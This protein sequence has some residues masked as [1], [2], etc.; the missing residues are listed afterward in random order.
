MDYAHATHPF[1]QLAA[2][3]QSWSALVSLGFWRSAFNG[4]GL[5]LWF[6]PPLSAFRR[7]VSGV[8]H[9]L[10]VAVRLPTAFDS[11]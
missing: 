6:V 10:A 11:I 5:Q 1:T 8:H 9:Q 7:L 4:L 3:G 2:A